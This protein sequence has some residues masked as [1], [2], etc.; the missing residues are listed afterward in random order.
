MS[1]TS[2]K[3][4]RFTKRSRGRKREKK[5]GRR[6]PPTAEEIDL[7]KKVARYGIG[8]DVHKHTI[9]VNV[10]AQLEDA[11]TVEVKHHV[12]RNSVNGLNELAQ[13]LRKYNPISHYLMECTGVYHLQLVYKLRETFPDRIEK[14]IPMNPLMIHWRITELGVKNDKADARDIALLSFYDSLLQ[15]SYVGSEYF[16]HLRDTMRSYH[17]IRTQT[18]RLKNRIT[19][20]LDSVN[21]KFPFNLNKEWCLELLDF[22]LSDHWSLNDAFH[23]LIE[24]KKK[25]GK[26]TNVL[27]KH[28][29]DLI[30]C[31][32]I[33]LPDELRFL[34]QLDFARYLNEDVAQSLL[35]REAE[36]QIL[37]DED[38]K[39]NYFK[40][41]DI[42]GVGNTTALTV[43][44]ELG[45]FRRFHRWQSL[46]KY[47]GVVPTVDKSGEYERKGHI[48]RYTN[49]ILRGVLTQAASNLV[50]RCDRSH[51]LG[52]FAHKQRIIRKLPYKKALIKVAQK[53]ARIIYFIL[54]DGISYDLNYELKQKRR[55]KRMRRLK[56]KNTLLESSKLRALKRNI[57]DF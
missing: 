19:R 14:I 33:I 20:R 22:Y 23:A 55:K 38:L 7:E 25:E 31:G 57:Q 16:Y 49:K 45:D 1:K 53:L 41:L 18:T 3:T 24:S 10:Q 13:F 8:F 17:K 26:S 29:T 32:S 40:L 11:T 21:Q 5:R 28:E 37:E 51:D 35:I 2:I 56:R 4:L 9:V 54:V 42:P 6:K 52:R 34:L 50:N 27:E 47:C 43:L 30:D 15:S 36:E 46:V 48:N 12:F 44:L 39:S